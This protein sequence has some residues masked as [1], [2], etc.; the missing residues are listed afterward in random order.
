MI[1]P[2]TH[3]LQAAGEA[4]G[5]GWWSAVRTLAAE[6]ALVEFLLILGVLIVLLAV[7]LRLSRLVRD[8]QSRVAV[9]DYLLGT[10]QALSGDLKGASTRLKK[11]LDQDP[12]NHHARLLYGEVLAE[13][14]EPAEAHK[15]HLFLQKAF[16]V[17]SLRND[18]N[19]TRELLDAGRAGEAVDAAR[20]G[21]ERSPDD[22]EALRMLF[23]AELAAG[24][25]E[26]AG[27]TGVRL[28]RVLDQDAERARV[29]ARAAAAFAL[30]GTV[31][32]EGGELDAAE[33]LCVEAEALDGSEPDVQR[34]RARLVFAREGK[35]ALLGHVGTVP[36]L[37]AE[38]DDGAAA[39][40]LVPVLADGTAA[41]SLVPAVAV[42]ASR[43]AALVPAT[44]YRCPTCG[45]PR[46]L[47]EPH[48]P[49]CGLSNR[50]VPVEPAL[51]AGLESPGAVID[52]VEAN[53]AHVRRQLALALEGDSTSFDD[54]VAIGGAAVE[55]IFASACRSVDPAP[56]HVELLRR[57]GPSALPAMFQAYARLKERHVRNLSRLL[58][59][60][61]RGTGVLGKVVQGFGRD[62]QPYFEQLLE[63]SDRDLRKVLLD[64]YIGLGD[65]NELHR[66]LEHF[67]PVE[68]L[69]RLNAAE[70]DPLV[71]LLQTVAGEGF[72]ASGLLVDPSFRREREMLL[73]VPDAADPDALIE[74]LA[75]RGYSPHLAVCLIDGLSDE[76]LAAAAGGLLDR[77]GPAAVDHMLS[78]FADL[79]RPA[80]ARERLKARL[81]A[82][83]ASLVEKVC[84]LLGP[85]ASSL[86]KDL[87][88]LL[89][90]LGPDGS[91]GLASAYRR[92][93]LLEKIGGRFGGAFVNRYNHRRVCIIKA[94]AAVG[95]HAELLRLRAEESDNNLK[96]RLAQALHT[97]PQARVADGDDA[98]AGEP[99][100]EEPRGQAG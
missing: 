28:L 85:A 75:R 79:D 3:A 52:E 43:V 19:L 90:L 100:S 12:E 30:A 98:T 97:E 23:A 24:F 74:V 36:Q 71:R 46:A 80:S 47:D 2:P 34:L 92:G 82:M 27:R 88:D 32:W 15:Q 77:L 69:H 67:P 14:G 89:V 10:E 29:R 16:A 76:R 84:A 65:E 37:A 38:G 94:L 33:A 40:P 64:Y 25:P 1:L 31:R 96:L 50:A 48:C 35:E 55:E 78:A 66:V 87:H 17:D 68:I 57:M 70:R 21:A 54:L 11:V 45:G 4:A 59:G 42:A 49:H 22:R 8:A 91:P 20:R 51:M 86:D 39:A 5:S 63:T 13:L 62:A 93:S 83:G 7:N 60:G 58:H 41:A 61:G 72:F 18:L 81:A 6:P 53:R 73:A 44:P 99:R 95:G 9:R 26:A 56:A